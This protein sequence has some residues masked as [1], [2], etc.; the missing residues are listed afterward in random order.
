MNIELY[1]TTIETYMT[2]EEAND[3]CIKLQDDWRLPTKEELIYMFNSTANEFGN[4]GCWGER[5]S[6]FYSWS[7]GF[8][9]G[10]VYLNLSD[11]ENY[12]RP[13]RDLK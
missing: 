9:T 8:K 7:V 3:Y 6:I 1:P 2:W 5:H 4:Y 11:N 12:L 13:V 10:N